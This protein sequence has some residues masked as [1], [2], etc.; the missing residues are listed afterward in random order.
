VKLATIALTSLLATGA[1]SSGMTRGETFDAPPLGDTGGPVASAGSDDE[2]SG[3]TAG[4]TGGE[5]TAGD[6]TTASDAA[7]EEGPKFDLA[8][9]T[10]TDAE[11]DVE[12][13]ICCLMPGDIPPH[14]L[15]DAFLA[16]YPPANMPKTLAEI[17]AW[18]P[19]ANGQSIT[20]SDANSGGELIDPANGGVTDAHVHEGRA[21]SRMQA[22][23]VM[24]ADAMVLDVR[25]DPVQI[26]NP[27][28]DPQCVGS[29]GAIGQAGIG[30][31]WGSILFE[32][33]DLAIHEVVYLYIG[34]CVGTTDHES[35][36]YS[37]SAAEICGPPG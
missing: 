26:D 36:W 20:W 25:E 27:G 22:E 13:D 21:L 33:P 15:L 4:G 12:D 31:A 30:W 9:G 11:C 34:L 6:D 8:G 35:F 2:S 14:A 28:G 7:S 29:S 32:T 5:G 18:N 19:M 23:T 16:A 37:E 10:D 17:E 1:C 3:S 24:P